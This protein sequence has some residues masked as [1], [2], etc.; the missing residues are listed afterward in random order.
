M[1]AS[2]ARTEVLPGGGP[3]WI[4]EDGSGTC[5][6][7]GV[8]VQYANLN[9]YDHPRQSVHRPPFV[10]QGVDGR[11]QGIEV[12]TCTACGQHVADWVWFDWV[13]GSGSMTVPTRRVVRRVA[14]YPRTRTVK[15][16]PEIP[17]FL[18]RDYIEAVA[19]AADS[20]RAAAALARRGL[21]A[22]LRDK[23]FV[24]PSKKLND[25]IELALKDPRTSTTLG[26]KL[27]FVQRVGND[28]AHPNRDYLGD[29]I[30]VT[31]GD[32]EVSIAALDEFFDAYYVKPERHAALMKARDERKKGPQS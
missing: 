11:A 13:Q 31:T 29:F 19:V 32:L 18:A 14:A 1:D 20:A 22:A 12:A 17:P 27:R 2:D 15:L 28:A 21:Q 24:A 10:K 5:P 6:H 9:A 30:D 3:H 23:G 25:E 16:D 4:E 26:E 8:P 7:C